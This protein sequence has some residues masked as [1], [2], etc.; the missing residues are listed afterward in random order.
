MIF[1]TG[2]RSQGDEPDEFFVVI[3]KRS[4]KIYHLA[5]NVVV[6]LYWRS[7]RLRR[8]AAD[9]ANGSQ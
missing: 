7:L 8:T 4:K 2:K 1:L 3:P 9:P 5:V 6:S